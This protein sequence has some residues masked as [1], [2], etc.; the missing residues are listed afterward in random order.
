MR[1]KGVGVHQIYDARA[2]RVVVGDAVGPAS[3]P[4]HPPLGDDLPS[5]DEGDASEGRQSRYARPLHELQSLVPLPRRP[6]H[7]GHPALRIEEGRLL[8]A[9]VVG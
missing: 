2:L 9:V 5:D 8:A 1:R 4:L 7:V 6:V 3:V